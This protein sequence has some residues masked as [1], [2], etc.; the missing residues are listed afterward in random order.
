MNAL[1]EERSFRKIEK[2]TEFLSHF[3]Y[4]FKMKMNGK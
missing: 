1:F 4:N 3:F 2:I